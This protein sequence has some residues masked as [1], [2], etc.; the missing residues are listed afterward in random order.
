MGN[1]ALFKNYKAGKKLLNGKS[2]PAGLSYKTNVRTLLTT[3]MM[4]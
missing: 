3:Y 1:I 2:W 4:Q